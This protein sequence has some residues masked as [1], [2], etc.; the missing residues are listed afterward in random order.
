MSRLSVLRLLLLFAWLLPAL[1]GRTATTNSFA[2]GEAAF[3]SGDVAGAAMV[4]ENAARQ[5]PSV[6]AFNN[7]GIIEWQRGRAG[8]AIL[9]W[10]RARWIDPF[11][12]DARQ[13]LTFARTV[14][15][16][17]EPEL[18]WYE[19]ASLWLPPNAW[20]WLAGATLWLAVGA[21]T[22]PPLFRRRRS[23]GLQWFAALA[24]GLFLFCLAANAGVV[25]RTQLGYVLKRNAPVQLT[26][27]REGEVMT[28]L[29][30]G[31]PVRRLKTRGN[32]YLVR[33]TFGTGWMERNNIGLVNGE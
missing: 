12:R 15:Q 32:Y 26:P 19:H 28:T 20:V 33:T 7:L 2:T 10:E 14:L 30:A 1:S 17:N 8:A 18:R 22:L 3:Q 25:S 23:S 29:A 31:E 13:N 27:T 21:M 9:A 24:F 16:A 11:D 6:G 4:F 5:N